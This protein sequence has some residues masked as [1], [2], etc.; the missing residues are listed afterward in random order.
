MIVT[1]TIWSFIS[2]DGNPAY[3]G[4]DIINIE[5]VLL[6]GAQLK[7]IKAF[8]SVNYD[9]ALKGKNTVLLKYISNLKHLEEEKLEQLS[10]DLKPLPATL[11]NSA[12]DEWSTQSPTST[13]SEHDLSDLSTDEFDELEGETDEDL[14]NEYFA[15]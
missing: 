10:V 5:K 8:Q 9:K 13:S 3:V 2:D 14:F 4:A 1:I 7:H 11:Q 6:M 15:D 12:S